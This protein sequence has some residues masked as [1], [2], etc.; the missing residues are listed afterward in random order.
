MPPRVYVITGSSMV[1]RAPGGLPETWD[2]LQRTLLGMPTGHG[3]CYWVTGGQQG[4]DYLALDILT[5]L[6]GWC[7][8]DVYLPAR[9]C[10]RERVYELQTTRCT[11]QGGVLPSGGHFLIHQALPGTDYRYR[12]L[13]MLQRAYGLQQ[14]D[15]AQV[16]VLAYPLYPERDAR[17]R[18]SGTW[19][20]VRQARAAGFPVDVHPLW[21]QA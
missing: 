6:R 3:W 5:G 10:A 13:L 9:R 4:V 14:R 8:H 7:E 21:R 15:G 17:S 19:L 16:L 18:R 12:N 1:A 11:S 20:C 2:T